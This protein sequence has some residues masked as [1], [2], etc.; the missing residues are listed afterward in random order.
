MKKEKLLIVPIFI[1]HEGCPYRCVFCNQSDITGSKHRA[2]KIWVERILK[3]YLSSSVRSNRFDRR[4]V[5][6]YGGSFTGLLPARQE[7]LLSLIQPWIE[8]GQVDAIRVST[9]PLFVDR[10]KLERLKVYRVKTVE[11]GVQSTDPEVLALSGRPCS[12]GELERAVSL[13]REPGFKMGLQLMSGLPGD[14]EKRFARSVKDVIALQ[15]DFVR[16][17]PALVLRHTSLNS[18]YREGRYVPWTLERTV[19]ALTGALKSFDR[20]GIPV[21]RMGLQQDRSLMEN[22]VAGPFH[23]SLRYL[24]DCRIG[25]EDMIRK[26][27]ALDRLPKRI[28]FRVPMKSISIYTG[29]HRENLSRL[30][31]RFGFEEVRVLGETHRQDLELVA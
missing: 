20:A 9:H 23:P 1:S 28:S 24:V 12:R 31:E 16:I 11:L 4:E 27:H 22:F 19:D 21:I 6:F 30:K 14:N 18:M 13:V 8:R 29:N 10:D 25:L 2:D 3:D 17:Y 15:P 26:I 5:A 7:N